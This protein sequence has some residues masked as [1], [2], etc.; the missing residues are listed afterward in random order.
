MIYSNLLMRQGKP[1]SFVDTLVKNTEKM[2]S[3]RQLQLSGNPVI[4]GAHFNFVVKTQTISLPVLQR[5]HHG[6]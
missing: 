5:S 4:L 1:G 6:S 2:Y 3:A